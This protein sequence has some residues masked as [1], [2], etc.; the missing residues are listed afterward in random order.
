[1]DD[2]RLIITCGKHRLIE[3]AKLYATAS[4]GAVN[5]K[6]KYSLTPYIEHPA[7]VANTVTG[8]GGTIEMIA[9]A[10]L[11]DVVEDTGITLE[12]LA[13]D[14]PKEVISLVNELTD[15]SKP[16]DGNRAARKQIDLERLAA[17]SP[18]AQTIKYADLIDNA[19]SIV[20]YDKTFAPIFLREMDLL[21]LHMTKG[22]TDLFNEAVHMLTTYTN[23]LKVDYS[24]LSKLKN[25]V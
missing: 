14:F 20:Y 22:N 12:Y 11:H 25:S 4:H 18:E 16:E 21:L 7:E 23:M 5:Q 8:C 13:N 3:K 15:K 17:A 24:V 9:A 6:R 19:R 1:M 2:C 10:W